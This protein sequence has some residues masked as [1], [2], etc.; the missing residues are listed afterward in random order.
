MA[1]TYIHLI[2]I[3]LKAGGD[4]YRRRN[5][6]FLKFSIPNMKAVE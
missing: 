1:T 4:D 2:Q 5:F 3:K 6:K